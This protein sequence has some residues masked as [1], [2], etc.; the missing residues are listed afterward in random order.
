[1]KK[2][3]LDE[4]GVDFLNMRLVVVLIVSALLVAVAVVCVNGYMDGISR[5]QA[6]REAGRIASLANA[7]YVT[8]CPG[9]GGKATIAVSIPG[10]VR[11]MGFGRYPG[12]N[13]SDRV[14]YIEFMDGSVETR[15]SDCPYIGE[16]PG[17][18]V[19]LYPGE[20]SLELE[21]VAINGTYAVAI[22]GS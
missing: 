6:M 7:E 1:M 15:L 4:E 13:E 3:M 16:T 5:G 21:A 9:T 2:S 11:R 12:T 22:H 19:V 17:S 8:G 10:C 14:Y 20:Y 18:G